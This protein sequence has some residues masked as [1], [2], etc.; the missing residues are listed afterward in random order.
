MTAVPAPANRWIEA[1]SPFIA[2]LG[3]A[4]IISWGTLYYSFPLIAGPM[5]AELGL[6][7]AEA[8]GAVSYT[9]LTLPTKRIV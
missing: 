3:V 5:A 8:Y 1:A 2:A 9:H 4:Q 7:R 6:G